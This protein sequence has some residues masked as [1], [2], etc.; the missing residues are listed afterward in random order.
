MSKPKI[1]PPN[2]LCTLMRVA[3]ASDPVWAMLEIVIAQNSPVQKATA[4]RVEG[5]A[6]SSVFITS[7]RS[8]RKGLLCRGCLRGI[9]ASSLKPR[10]EPVVKDLSKDQGLYGTA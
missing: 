8:L 5:N 9:A 2:L 4:F 7:G 1:S 6:L 3:G 10:P